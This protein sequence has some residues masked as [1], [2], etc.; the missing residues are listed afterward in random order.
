[1]GLDDHFH[2]V[3][4]AVAHPKHEGILLGAGAFVFEHAEVSEAFGQGAHER[5]A[6][7]YGPEGHYLLIQLDVGLGEELQVAHLGGGELFYRDA[8]FN[9]TGRVFFLDGEEVK[10]C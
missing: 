5:F 9:F 8:G 3:Q 1:M 10:F 6:P 4:C 7:S 2:R